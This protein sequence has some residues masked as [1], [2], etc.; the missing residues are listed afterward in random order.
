[1]ALAN[2]DVGMFRGIIVYTEIW[3]LENVLKRGEGGREALDDGD[4]GSHGIHLEMGRQDIL[5]IIQRGILIR[6]AKRV[7]P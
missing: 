4:L 6:F 1:M 3:V 5:R 7:D 2:R